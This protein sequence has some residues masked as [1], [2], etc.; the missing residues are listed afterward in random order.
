MKKYIGTK[1]PQD[2]SLLMQLRPLLVES[3]Q[4]KLL[5]LKTELL[6]ISIAER[7][8]SVLVNDFDQF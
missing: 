6:S 4:R 2:D 1:F 5:A 8:L 7:S 3:V